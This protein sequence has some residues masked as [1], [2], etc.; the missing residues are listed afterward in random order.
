MSYDGKIG[1]ADR[2]K[3]IA[4]L[5]TKPNEEV[6]WSARTKRFTHSVIFVRTIGYIDICGERPDRELGL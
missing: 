1:D 6:R 3:R 4:E 5:Q 2:A